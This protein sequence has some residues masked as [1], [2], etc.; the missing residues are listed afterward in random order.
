MDHNRRAIDSE[1]GWGRI[2]CTA[3]DTGGDT[4]GSKHL[5]MQIRSLSGLFTEEVPMVNGS[6]LVVGQFD[7]SSMFYA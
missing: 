4:G 2:E 1:N 3:G 5:L 6:S 7:F